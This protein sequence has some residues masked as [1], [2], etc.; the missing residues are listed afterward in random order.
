[1]IRERRESRHSGTGAALPALAANGY[2]ITVFSSTMTRPVF[3]ISKKFFASSTAAAIVGEARA[4]CIA[5]S[6]S[7]HISPTPSHAGSPGAE[8]TW[9]WTHFAS[10]GI[11][12]M[13]AVCCSP[14]QYL[15]QA[16]LVVPA[17]L[18]RMKITLGMAHLL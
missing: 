10:P 3:S 17:F 16:S 11:V 4:L 5:S 2:P 9:F 1:V 6:L 8:M 7:N 14:S 18:C 12:L 15:S 13:I